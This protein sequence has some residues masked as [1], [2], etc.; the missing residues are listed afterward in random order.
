[1]AKKKT[2][3]Q[4]K[5]KSKQLEAMFAESGMSSLKAGLISDWILSLLKK[6]KPDLSKLNLL[7][8]RTHVMGLA[9]LW[10]ET[11]DLPGDIDDTV[12]LSG[13][14]LLSDMLEN[15]LRNADGGDDD[16]EIV[17]RGVPQ[18]GIEA[19]METYDAQAVKDYLDLLGT[20]VPDANR[21]KLIK[22]PKA[23]AALRR[24]SKENQIKVL[25]SSTLLDILIKWGP[26]ALK[27]IM[28]LLGGF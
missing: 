3:S 28:L 13:A 2:A 26:L 21:K 18:G 15:T 5:G 4:P 25:Q 11:T 24:L 9:R 7:E 12:W 16:G 20:S 10:A 14:D 27:I 17:L 22:N 1:M 19:E 8:H 6:F 23:L